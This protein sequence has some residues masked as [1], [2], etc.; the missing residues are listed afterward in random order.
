MKT[1]SAQSLPAFSQAPELED[2]GDLSLPAGAI[3][4]DAGCGDG[5]L[6]R[7]MLSRF[8]GARFEGCD[9][10]ELRVKDA[11]KQ[12][13][14]HGMSA[15]KFFRSPLDGIDA[16]DSHYDAVICRQGLSDLERPIE[17]ARELLRVLKPGGQAFLIE[18]DGMW[19]NLFPAT[20]CLREMLALIERN[21][22]LDLKLGRKV[23]HLAMDVGFQRLNWRVEAMQFAGPSLEQECKRIEQRMA[24]AHPML[25]K[26]LGGP[27]RAA[28]FKRRF[29]TEMMQPGAVL[30][31]NKFVVHGWK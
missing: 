26:A 18:T 30:F 14:G 6:T 15:L 9:A 7:A 22:P 21:L 13:R 11:E 24:L 28:E 2:L 4:L 16:P 8:P 20:P 25:C 3:A 19:L 29:M 17:G 1:A 23:P 27:K 5:T 10:S 31:Y 12:S